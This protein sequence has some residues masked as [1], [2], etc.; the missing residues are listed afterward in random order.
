M[1]FIKKIWNNVIKKEKGKMKIKS[2]KGEI[3]T[4]QIV[5]LIIL[6]VSFIIILFFLFRLNPGDEA[7]KEACHQSVVLRG[8]NAIPSDAIPL[9]CNTKYLCITEDGTCER[10]TKPDV[11]KVKTK[12][13]IYDILADEMADCWWMF[14][15]G[16]LNYVGNDMKH[17]FYCSLCTQFVL[18]D[19]LTKI[20]DVGSEIDGKDFYTYLE[21]KHLESEGM[22]YLEYLTGSKTIRDL[23]RSMAADGGNFGS[24]SLV[25]QHYIMMGI[26]SDIGV[27]RWI[28]IG[29]VIGSLIAVPFTSGASLAVTAVILGGAG[30]VAGNYIGTT[31]KGE[32]G[33]EYLK[34]V[35]IE[36]N[37]R[38]FD[39]FSCKNVMTLS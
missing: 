28:T 21:N 34:P 25:K 35:I 38:E 22:S 18:D 39:G 11:E 12:E 19:S 36:A 26:Y 4:Q 30:G 6:I 8:N 7:D 32:S 13:E 2:K 14:G 24:Y 37:S 33:F 27:Y 5:L 29:A 1:G 23:E 10:L 31:V 20:K 15:E 3:S 9:K 17:N 16:D